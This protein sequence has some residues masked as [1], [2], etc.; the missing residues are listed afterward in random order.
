VYVLWGCLGRKS[1]DERDDAGG[2][3]NSDRS[4]QCATHT[5]QNGLS[6]SAIAYEGRANKSGAMTRNTID[7][8]LYHRSIVAG[9]GTC[10]K[11]AL[12]DVA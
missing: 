4:L 12:P 7:G 3:K 9:G 6:N 5:S 1:D 2:I 10:P 8:A 11:R